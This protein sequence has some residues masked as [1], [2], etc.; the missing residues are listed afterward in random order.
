MQ[1]R[2]RLWPDKAT[3]TTLSRPTGRLFLLEE[4]TMNRLITALIIV[5]PLL[6]DVLL[7]HRSGGSSENKS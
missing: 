2:E 1:T 4:P 3:D 5:I 7:K 6:L